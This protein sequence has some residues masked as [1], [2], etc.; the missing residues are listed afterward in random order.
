MKY[1]Q[2]KHPNSRN[3]FKKGYKSN[4]KGKTYEEILGSAKRVEERKKKFSK[5]TK[6]KKQTKE[7]IEKRI[8]KLRNKKRAYPF[9]ITRK[10]IA[11]SH[12]GDKSHF[13]RGGKS[14]ELYGDEFTKQ[15]KTKIRKRDRFV[16]KSCN[17]N[18]W[19]VHHIDYNKKN[20]KE[21]NLITLCNSCHMKTNFNRENWINYFK[22][23]NIN[24]I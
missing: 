7:H 19:C 17:K 18:G 24:K 12:R 16:C 11:N 5:K 1:S 4:K 15:L 8:S 6:G 20:S 2:G 13:W 14:Y 3:G 22:E 21:D 23:K 9:E 10:K